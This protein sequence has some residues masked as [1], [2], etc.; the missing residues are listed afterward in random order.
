MRTTFVVDIIAMTFG[1]PRVLFPVVGAVVIGG[2]AVTVGVLTASYAVGAL[3]SSVFSGRLGHVRL[4]GRAVDRAITVYGICI[5]AFGLVLALTAPRGDGGLTE[6][7]GQADL[8]ALG[9]AALALAG[10]GAADNVS[11]IF[12][13]TILQTAA[14]DHM[15]G[16][17]QGVFIVVVTG[18]PRV[19]DLFVGLVA[20]A[21]VGVAAAARRGADRRADRRRGTAHAVV[22]DVRRAAP[23]A[24][25]AAASAA[26]GLTS[27]AAGG[28]GRQ[29]SCWAGR[30]PV[31]L[32]R[33]GLLRLA[34]QA[35]LP[36]RRAAAGRSVGRRRPS[37]ERRG[38]RLQR[39]PAR[40]ERRQQVGLVA[41]G[42]LVVPSACP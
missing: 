34:A 26:V 42:A 9:A 38:R 15:R 31:L 25:A 13:S 36:D 5:A 39:R 14:P 16:R 41:A 12:R 10:A 33:A 11:S 28:G 4:Q 22:P 29:G 40:G 21:G 23:D 1:Q 27:R 18:G 37:D 8:V 3:L 32:L 6:G 17:L 19:G 2:G 30:L 20:A 35:R 24:V 7:L